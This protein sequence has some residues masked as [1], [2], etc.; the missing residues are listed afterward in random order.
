MAQLVLDSKLINTISSLAVKL[1][2]SKAEIVKRAVDNYAEGVTKNTKKNRLMAYAGILPEEEADEI[3]NSIYRSRKSKNIDY[4]L[5]IILSI[6]ISWSIFSRIIKRSWKN[7]QESA[8]R[9]FLQPYINYTELLFGAYNSIKVEQNLKK[10]KSFLE[11]INVLDFDK[12]AA[13]K[14]RKPGRRPGFNDSKYLFSR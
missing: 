5:W 9:I 1:K 10:F 4:R 14:G 12:A 6:P 3:L 2:T 11:D 7:F 13:E 8:M